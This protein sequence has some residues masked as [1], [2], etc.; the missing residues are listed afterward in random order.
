[1]SDFR[2]YLL[3]HITDQA[4]QKLQ[5]LWVESGCKGKGLRIASDLL[6]GDKLNVLANSSTVL[7]V[8]W[9][10]EEYGTIRE[11]IYLKWQS[12]RLQ[13]V[14]HGSAMGPLPT[15]KAKPLGRVPAGSTIPK[16]REGPLA[17]SDTP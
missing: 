11:S 15:Q 12:S 7:S 16:R 2:V 10:P 13:I 14:V 9:Q 5:V 8:S 6:D 4:F 3:L 1:M 17:R